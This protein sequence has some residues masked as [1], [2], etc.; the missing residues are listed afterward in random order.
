M[1]PLWL[2]YEVGIWCAW[3]VERRRTRRARAAGGAAS[4]AGL[5][6]LLLLAG[7]AVAAQTPP[8]APPA[9]ADTTPRTAADSAAQGRLD[10][11]TA[12]RL[13]LPT[14]PTRTFPPSDAVIDSLIK[15]QG[16]RV[17]QYV[18]DTL[19]VQGGDTETIHLR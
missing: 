10:T 17:T 19:I 7:G 13:G 1:V 12:R 4:A 18:S 11:A 15:L 8:P 14:G 3:V 5:A 6:A 16:Y 9:R 2:L